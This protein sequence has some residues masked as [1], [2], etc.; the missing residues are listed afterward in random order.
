MR[1]PASCG[2][3]IDEEVDAA[4]AEHRAAVP[5]PLILME[6]TDDHAYT[7]RCPRGHPIRFALQN[8]RYELLY[9]CGVMAMHCGFNREAVAG[10]GTAL[11]RFY[12]F[13][14]RVFSNH[15]GVE[16]GHF[17]DVWGTIKKQSERQLGAFLV[18][19]LFSFKQPFVVPP[20]CRA[21]APM[22]EFR[23]GVVHA[24]SIPT[25]ADTR[26][27]AKEVFEIV[28]ATKAKLCDLNADAVRIAELRQY[29]AAQSAATKRMP[30]EIKTREG[31]YLAS[32]GAA[33][34]MVLATN[35]GGG[36]TFEQRF[37]EA[38]HRLD[39]WGLRAPL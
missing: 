19:Y 4:V 17:D 29:Q 30:E 25:A 15:H 22:S 23:N 35:F 7:G 20:G 6:L 27:Y 2:A 8:L 9:E 21:L 1:V 11:E 31:R 16:P 28:R 38:K 36:D 18:G 10:F 24:G 3:C 13:S 26:R 12:E 33:Y 14:L 37:D 34:A 5:P 32:S 39:L